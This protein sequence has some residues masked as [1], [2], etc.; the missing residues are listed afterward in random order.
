MSWLSF[1]LGVVAGF[2]LGCDV[3]HKFMKR[4]GK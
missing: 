1:G 2:A 4:S 3:M